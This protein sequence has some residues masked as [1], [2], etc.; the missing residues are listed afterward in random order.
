MPNVAK[1]APKQ[2]FPL[3]KKALFIPKYELTKSEDELTETVDKQASP[4]TTPST[5]YNI[6]NQ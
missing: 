1:K 4:V 3:E 6:K 2:L 5:I